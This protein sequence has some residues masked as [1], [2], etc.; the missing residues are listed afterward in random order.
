LNIVQIFV[1]LLQVPLR[2]LIGVQFLR[3]LNER[4]EFNE[5][6]RASDGIDRRAVFV[7][8]FALQFWLRK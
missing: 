1:Q 4:V 8:E 3:L 7:R 6:V 2:A 5:R